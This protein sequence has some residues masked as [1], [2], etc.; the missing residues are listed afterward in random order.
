M[1][2]VVMMMIVS[3]DDKANVEVGARVQWC[4]QFAGNSTVTALCNQQ[5]LHGLLPHLP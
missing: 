2:V 1:V 5:Q 3:V 4:R